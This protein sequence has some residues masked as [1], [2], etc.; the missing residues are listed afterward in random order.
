M[1]TLTT[2]D[3]IAK[4]S[5]RA[6]HISNTEYVIQI[7]DLES[8]INEVIAQRAGWI[9]VKDALPPVGC[10]VMTMPNYRVL[11]F[12]NDGSDDDAPVDGF[13]TFNDFMETTEIVTNVT[14]WI[15]LPNPPSTTL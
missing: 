8:L 14:H 6:E 13:W 4:Y 15:P 10:S 11:P 2:D 3:L 5:I 9:S 7:K 1:N 12:G